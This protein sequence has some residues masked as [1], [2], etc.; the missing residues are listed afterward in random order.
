LPNYA[1][2]CGVETYPGACYNDKLDWGC[3]APSQARSPATCRGKGYTGAC[4][5]SSHGI[6][7]KEE[8]VSECKSDCIAKC[9]AEGKVDMWGACF[10]KHKAGVPHKQQCF[11]VAKT[12]DSGPPLKYVKNACLTKQ[13]NL[14]PRTY[15]ALC[16]LP[17]SK[18]IVPSTQKVVFKRPQPRR[19][20]VTTTTTTV[21]RSDPKCQCQDSETVNGVSVAGKTGC[22]Y[23]LTRT[24]GKF[25]Y[26]N[27]GK[28]CTGARFSKKVGLHWRK[29]R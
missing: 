24:F 4:M 28:E 5:H 13:I 6:M 14:L 9:T 15:D 19:A 27:G 11:C 16:K 29:C 20:G 1:G 22:G 21:A 25:C 18:F 3:F 23:H 10:V 26:I 2:Q 7:L 12:A 17:G 8:D